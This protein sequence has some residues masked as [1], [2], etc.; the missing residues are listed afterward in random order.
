MGDSDIGGLTCAYKY[1]HLGILQQKATKDP[2][3]DPDYY[4]PVSFEYA[5]V[6]FVLRP[7]RAHLSAMPVMVH[8]F[9]SRS[10]MVG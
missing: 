6:F 7:R 1:P 10:G 2:V 5:A 9:R 4:V 8:R 3:K